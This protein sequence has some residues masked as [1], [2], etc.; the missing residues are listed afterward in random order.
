MEEWVFITI[1]LI[2]VLCE[3]VAQA[4][5]NQ[6]RHT[7][8][9]IYLAIG[10]LFYTM[11]VFLLSMAH[12]HAPMG[13]VNSIWSGAS[14]IAISTM[15]YMFFDQKITLDKMGMMGV[16]AIGVAYLSLSE[17]PVPG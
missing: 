9:F 4:S 14:V 13:V 16:I 3:A 5:A 11:V 15:G 10:G 8:N 17:E 6:L 12:K 7:D 1:I 2:I